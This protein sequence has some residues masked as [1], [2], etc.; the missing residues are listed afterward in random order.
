MGMGHCL[1]RRLPISINGAYSRAE[2][3][4][5]CD[6]NKQP[7]MHGRAA[8]ARRLAAR[9]SREEWETV[10]DSRLLQDAAWMAWTREMIACPW[11][12]FRASLLPPHLIGRSW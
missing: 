2:H 1:D 8:A 5:Q 3:L 9:K 11:H 10:R 7:R 4:V 12:R 6:N